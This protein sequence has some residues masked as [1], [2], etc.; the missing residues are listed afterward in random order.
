LLWSLLGLFLLFGFSPTPSYTK[1]ANAERQ[2][3]NYCLYGNYLL[4]HHYKQNHIELLLLSCCLVKAIFS[5]LVAACNQ[6]SYLKSARSELAK[7]FSCLYAVKS[8]E[9]LSDNS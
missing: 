6:H 9:S 7:G 3:R 8:R 1:Y 2:H 4:L 5:G